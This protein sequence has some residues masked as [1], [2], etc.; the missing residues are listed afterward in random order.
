[1]TGPYR[2]DDPPNLTGENGTLHYGM[3]SRGSTSDP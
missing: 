2:L 1:M 3:D